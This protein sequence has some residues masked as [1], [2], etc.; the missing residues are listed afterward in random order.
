VGRLI[1]KCILILLASAVFLYS[2][3]WLILQAKGANG[4]GTVEVHP[5]YAVP[6]KNGKTEFILSDPENVP[7]VHSMFPHRGQQ[8]CWYLSGKQQKRI[9]M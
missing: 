3:D 8:P 1:R 5:Y 7:C 2:A 4:A 9:D 6:Q